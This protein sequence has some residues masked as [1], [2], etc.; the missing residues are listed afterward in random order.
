MN[1]STRILIPAVTTS[2]NKVAPGQG[3][4]KQPFTIPVKAYDPYR[5]LS[6]FE[7]VKVQNELASQSITPF[8]AV[9]YIQVL[10]NPASKG[11]Y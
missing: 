5:N 4:D 8:N 7:K 9:D 11:P 10:F 6:H 3:Q 2:S 1:D